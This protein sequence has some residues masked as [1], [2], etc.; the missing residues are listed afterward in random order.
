VGAI[1]SEREDALARVSEVRA[2]LLANAPVADTDFD[3]L[4]RQATNELGCDL[5][6][7]L[8]AMWDLI[9]SHKLE[10]LPGSRVRAFAA[11]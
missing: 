3:I 11:A 10:L 5:T 4:L 6:T 8:A 2:W 1:L 9:S 7:T